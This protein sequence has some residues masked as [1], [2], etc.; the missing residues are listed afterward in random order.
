MSILPLNNFKYLHN[1]RSL[2]PSIRFDQLHAGTSKTRIFR[3]NTM[4]LPPP[5]F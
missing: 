5:A 1:S 2:I 4:R 3:R